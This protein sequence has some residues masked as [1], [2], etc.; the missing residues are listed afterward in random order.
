MFGFGA[1]GRP[2][3]QVVFLVGPIQADGRF[4][5]IAFI[6]RFFVYARHSG[7]AAGEDLKEF[8]SAG[9]HLQAKGSEYSL[10]TRRRTRSEPLQ[11]NVA[12]LECGIRLPGPAC[13]TSRLSKNKSRS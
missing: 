1:V 2:D 3:P 9:L 8:V 5:L 10:T 11:K 7:P 13:P 6:H 4:E 12:T